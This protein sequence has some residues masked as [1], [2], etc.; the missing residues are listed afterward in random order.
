MTTL[1]F[2]ASA[3]VGRHL[4]RAIAAD[5]QDL[6]II[7]RNPM[8]LEAEAA[9]CR[10]LYDVNVDLIA[11]DASDPARV[12]DVL[13]EHAASDNRII[14]NLFF[15]IGAAFENDEVLNSAADM[16][17]VLHVNLTSVMVAISALLPQMIS[18]GEGN[19]VGFG[20]I[21]GIRGRR[22]NVVYSAA[23][24]GLE[25]YFESLRHATASTGICVQF[26]RLGYIG[27][28]QSYGRKLLFPILA[29]SA[30]ARRV[31]ANLNRDIG[32]VSIPRFW[33]AIGLLLKFLPWHIYR[34]LRF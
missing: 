13:L 28:Q 15:P 32:R 10:L 30:V 31:V 34:R 12:Y 26:Y 21:A 1:I 20:S 7:A 8:D 33:S 6:L 4:C 16:S 29:P 11:V 25:S 23:K 19:I 5:G 18:T 14:R 9:H 17:S 2:G 24:R 22:T 27:T 3:G